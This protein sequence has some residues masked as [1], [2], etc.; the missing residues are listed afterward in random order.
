M[1]WPQASR[2]RPDQRPEI[3]LP[4][5]CT[6]LYQDWWAGNHIE[7][8]P[9]RL[10]DW[11]TPSE[12]WASPASRKSV[13]NCADTRLPTDGVP[14]RRGSPSTLL[15]GYRQRKEGVMKS[16]LIATVLLMGGFFC[17]TA[18]AVDGRNAVGVCIDAGPKCAWS[19]NDKGEVDLCTANGCWYCPS[20]TSECVPARTTRPKPSNPVRGTIVSTKIGWYEVGKNP[21]IDKLLP[22][23]RK[24]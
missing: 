19:V 20:A 18:E 2:S 11:H 17:G 16:L 13:C 24:P 10:D 8:D 12:C 14:L 7:H 22:P 4:L 1:S 23:A 15:Q 3:G 6:F 21:G 9:M 5:V